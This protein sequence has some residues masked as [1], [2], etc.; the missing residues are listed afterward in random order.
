VEEHRFTDLADDAALFLPDEGQAAT[1]LAFSSEAAAP[2]GLKVSW[3]KT[4]LQNLGYGPQSSD[5][6]IAGSMVEGVEEFL[7][8]GSKQT[9]DGRTLPDVARRKGLVV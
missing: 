8:L 4:K 6:T 9:S 3:A 1:T 2:F 5:T 7:Y